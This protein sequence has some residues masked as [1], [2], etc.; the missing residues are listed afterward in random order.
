MKIKI[1]DII[2]PWYAPRKADDNEFI[3]NLM[4][5]L[6]DSGQ[7]NPIMVRLN[8]NKEYELIAGLQRTTAAKKL[9][10]EEIEANVY[11][12]SEEEA[13]LLALETNLVRKE[14]KEIEEGKAIKEMMDRLNLK[15]Q[16]IANRIGKSQAWV[17]N[18]LSLSLD[19][20]ERVRDM[21]TNN[22]ISP[23]QA[24]F[25]SKIDPE[26]QVKFTKIIIEKQNELNK[27]LNNDEIKKELVRYKNNTIYTIGYEG[28]NIKDFVKV[29]KENKIDV[30]LDVRESTKSLQKPQFSEEFL[31]QTLHSEK[32]K[33]ITRKDLG[34]P[35]LIRESFIKGGLPYDCFEYWYTWHI[36]K[37]EENK[38]PQLIEMIKSQG[39]TALMCYEKD[40]NSCHRNILANLIMNTKSFEK[41]KDISSKQKKLVS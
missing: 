37:R 23:T 41:R 9:G 33:Y 13:A 3:D 10:W 6:S 18:R 27:K 19:L 36:T 38:L 35:Y 34:A 16:E 40:V 15:Q 26:E 7:W 22:L 39:K 11:D 31:D 1:K 20:V 28:I 32:I 2:L 29:L 25:I 30:L 4:R 24:I 17:S 14:L 8:Q 21:I 12:V 5:S